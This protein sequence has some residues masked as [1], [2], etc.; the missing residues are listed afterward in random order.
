MQK[1]F[2]DSAYNRENVDSIR[3]VGTLTPLFLNQR[4]LFAASKRRVH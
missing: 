3:N 2:W 1:K 4:L